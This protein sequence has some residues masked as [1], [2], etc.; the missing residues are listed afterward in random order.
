M[1]KPKIVCLGDSLT[2]GYGIHPYDPSKAW[3]ALL[4]RMENCTVSNAGQPGAALLE[5]NGYWNSSL[6]LKEMKKKPEAVILWLGSNDSA[7]GLYQKTAF[8]RGYSLMSEEL[9]EHVTRDHLLLIAPTD[10][11]PGLDKDVCDFGIRPEA[12]VEIRQIIHETADLFGVSCLDLKDLFLD[13]P[14][15]YSDEIHPDAEGNRILAEKI[16]QKVEE[17]GW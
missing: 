1:K 16:A 8:Q 17:L 6:Y 5:G 11:K 12:L 3:P 14:E 13:H 9:L 10:P 15:V 4:G 2:Y 7:A